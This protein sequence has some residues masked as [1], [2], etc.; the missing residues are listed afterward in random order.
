MH[1]NILFPTKKSFTVKKLRSKI[2]RE[3]R[4]VKGSTINSHPQNSPN[5][6]YYN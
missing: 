2:E 1:H 6:I 4:K 5:T 3:G